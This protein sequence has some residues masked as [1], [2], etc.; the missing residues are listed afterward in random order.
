MPEKLGA[1][2][3]RWKIA[4]SGPAF[5]WPWSVPFCYCLSVCGRAFSR[6]AHQEAAKGLDSSW[7]SDAHET[8]PPARL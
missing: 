4:I 5:S 6:S 8:G 1:I 2:G 3:G 7:G